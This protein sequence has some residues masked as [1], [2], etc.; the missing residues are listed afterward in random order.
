MDDEAKVNS[1]V[2]VKGAALFR[3]E[4][5]F[6]RGLVQARKVIMVLDLDNTILHSTDISELS[7]NTVLNLKDF[8]TIPRVDVGPEEKFEIRHPQR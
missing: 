8:Y 5:E 4:E 6:I 1:G 3:Q 7:M 2:M